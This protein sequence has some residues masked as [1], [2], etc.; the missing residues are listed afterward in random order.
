MT[1]RGE[2]SIHTPKTLKGYTTTGNTENIFGKKNSVYKILD[3]ENLQS[4]IRQC[5]QDEHCV[6]LTHNNVNKKTYLVDDIG[7]GV[8]KSTVG[9]ITWLK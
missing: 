6:G 9:D 3:H 8:F 1:D 5:Q 2:W 4:S 7:D